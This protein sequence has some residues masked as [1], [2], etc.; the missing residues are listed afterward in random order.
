MGAC[1][2]RSGEGYPPAS[3]PEQCVLQPTSAARTARPL[4]TRHADACTSTRRRLPKPRKNPTGQIS[5]RIQHALLS[6]LVF[7]LSSCRHR[8]RRVAHEPAGPGLRDH[9]GVVDGALGPNPRSERSFRRGD[10]NGVWTALQR[11]AQ[12]DP[13]LKRTVLM[14]V[15]LASAVVPHGAPG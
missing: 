1:R 12:S 15:P 4:D 3:V 6:P 11:Q 2:R 14:V 13:L 10:P 5:C 8:H 7:G 9:P